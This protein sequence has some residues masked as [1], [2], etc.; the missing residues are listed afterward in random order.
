MPIQFRFKNPGKY[1]E[2][3]PLKYAEIFETEEDP[4]FPFRYFCWQPERM[5]PEARQSCLLSNTD[6]YSRLPHS[7]LS[8]IKCQD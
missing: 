6:F 5:S 2:Y 3:T 8:W 4:S 1:T 7:G